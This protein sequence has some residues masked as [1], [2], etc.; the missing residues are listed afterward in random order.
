MNS[1]ALCLPTCEVNCTT[2]NIAKT[3]PSTKP[4]PHP[5]NKTTPT[6][7]VKDMELNIS[8]HLGVGLISGPEILNKPETQEQSGCIGNNSFSNVSVKLYIYCKSSTI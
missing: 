5:P 8:F 2:E 6:L 4:R 1:K 7:N 3:S